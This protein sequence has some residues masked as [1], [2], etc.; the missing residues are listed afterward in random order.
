MNSDAGPS[1]AV[2]PGAPTRPCGL[3]SSARRE[4]KARAPAPA[5]PDASSKQVVELPGR[6]LHFTATA[7]FVR[8]LDRADKPEVDIATTAYTLDGT[9]TAS[10]PVTFVVN[11]G[12]GMASAW[13]QM[14]AVGP[15]RI[16][17]SVG[18]S[19]PSEPAPNAD[20][21]LDFTD[22]VFID[23][24]GTGFSRFIA[25]G[26]DV[27]KRLWS[28]DGDIDALAQTIRRWLDKSGRELSPKFLPGRKLRRLSGA[29]ACAQTCRRRW[30]RPAR[31]GDGFA[32][33]RLRQPQRGLRPVQ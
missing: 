10:R 18:P 13:L 2:R 6:T 8:L 22:L 15:W 25:T 32:A 30:R 23:P 29:T 26:D 9:D 21:W 27:R 12:P 33:A 28:V 24:A 19:A 1:F 17:I 14:G 20:T 11:G 7:G 31:A 3:G 16:P 4:R 5:E